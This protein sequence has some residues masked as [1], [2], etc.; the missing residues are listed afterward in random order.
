MCLNNFFWIE[1]VGREIS[2]SVLFC[3][4]FYFLQLLH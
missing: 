2:L 3:K 1:S 4:C